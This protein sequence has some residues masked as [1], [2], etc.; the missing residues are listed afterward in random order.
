[1]KNSSGAG[2]FFLLAQFQ[3]KMQFSSLFIQFTLEMSST[4][5]YTFAH[6]FDIWYNK[7]GSLSCS[8]KWHVN[9]DQCAYVLHSNYIQAMTN[10]KTTQKKQLLL[11][12]IHTEVITQLT[13]VNESTFTG[14]AMII[15]RSN[16]RSG[17]N[18][19]IDH[20]A[21]SCNRR[22]NWRTKKTE[23]T[24]AAHNK[25]FRMQFESKLDFIYIICKIFY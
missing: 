8:K 17:W 12:V 14:W 3:L 21:S 25:L 5:L 4:E 22:E 9:S 19:K 1:M 15:N 24:K 20:T 2:C 18:T 6:V 23:T 7:I 13:G 11:S 16:E 10:K